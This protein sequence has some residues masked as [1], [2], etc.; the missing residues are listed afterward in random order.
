MQSVAR[1]EKEDARESGKKTVKAAKKSEKIT[2][3]S[4]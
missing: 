3:K 2:E 4:Q 1:L